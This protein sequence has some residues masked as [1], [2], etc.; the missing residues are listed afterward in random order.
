MNELNSK[1]KP[2]RK[3]SNRTPAAALPAMVNK[4]RHIQVT[5]PPGMSEDRVLCDLVSHGMATNAATAMRF[6]RAEHGE[7]SLTDM[8]ASL[9]DQGEAVNRGDFAGSERMLN[10]QAVAL[11]AIFGELAR[12]AALNMGEHLAA[13]EIYMRLALKAQSQSR[14]TFETLAAI[15]NPPVVFARQMNVAHGPQQ[16]NNGTAPNGTPANAHPGEVASLPKELLE[17]MTHGR[18]QLDNRATAATGRKNPRVEP[19]GAINRPA[20]R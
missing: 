15:K 4:S 12:R 18:T 9:R 3:A 16:V 7:L 2:A 17:D 6:V 13:T 8:V 10:A 11:N 1:P 14:A 20:K 19:V 5:A